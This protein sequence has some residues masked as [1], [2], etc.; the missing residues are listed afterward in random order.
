MTRHPGL[1]EILNQ[2]AFT[3][4]RTEHDFRR[5]PVDLTLEQTINADAASR[6]TGITSFTNDYSA[7]LRWMETK[8]TRASFISLLQEMTGLV[9][10]EDVT[11]EL[12]PR[13]I[14]RDNEDLRKITKQIL[15][16]SNLFETLNASEVLYNISTGKGTDEEV[17]ESLLNVPTKGKARHKEFIKSCENDPNKFESPIKKENVKT[18]VA[19]CATN[20]RT[21]N[22]KIAALK[23]SRDLM[24]HLL[25][26]TIKKRLDLQHILQYP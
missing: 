6:L 17:R 8:A 4:R 18:F 26:L 15:D 21:R 11:A 3:V 7:R 16:T 5:N 13:R 22:T 10:K 12:R 2:G 1:R 14:Q 23:G 19:G 25:V 24:G 9:S 20:R